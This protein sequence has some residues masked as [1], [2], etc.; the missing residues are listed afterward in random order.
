LGIPG[1]TNPE[2]LAA[3]FSLSA[4]GLYG[5]YIIPIFLRVTVCRE[6]FRPSEFNLGDFSIPIGWISVFWGLFMIS[7]LSLPDVYPYSWDNLNYSPVILGCVLLYAIISWYCSAAYWFKGQIRNP[8][9]EEMLQAHELSDE[10]EWG[11]G[12]EYDH[13]KTRLLD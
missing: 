6:T 9:A 4:I 3:L 5:S 11:S 7:I 13:E 2:V 1:L 10:S 12:D 8:K